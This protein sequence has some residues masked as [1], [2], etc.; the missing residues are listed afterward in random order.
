MN[1]RNTPDVAANADNVYLFYSD[2]QE[3]GG[4]GGTSDAAPLWA[5][6]TALINQQAAADG[7]PSVGFL[8]PAL[9]ALASGAN[10]A[11]LF[12]DITSGNNTWRESPTLFYAVPGYDLCCGLGSMNGTNLINALAGSIPS[13]SFLPPSLNAGGLTLTWTSVPGASYQLQYT[14]DLA[15]SNWINIG[16][17]VIASGSITAASDTFTNSQRFYRVL[18]SP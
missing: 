15:A 5:G 17:A 4:W 14:S 7:L 16:P 10:Y 1:W 6:F 11:N 18:V 12:H 13:P 8:N 9:Y 3:G 2:G